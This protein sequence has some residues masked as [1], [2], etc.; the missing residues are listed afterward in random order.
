MP[1]TTDREHFLPFGERQNQAHGLPMPPFTDDRF[2]PQLRGGGAPSEYKSPTCE[3]WESASNPHENSKEDCNADKS[4]PQIDSRDRDSEHGIFSRQGQ[5]TIHSPLNAEVTS[6][7]D[8]VFGKV[9]CKQPPVQR[10]NRACRR[11][12]RRQ[13]PHKSPEKVTEVLT[14]RGSDHVASLETD[15]GSM[16]GSLEVGYQEPLGDPNP[17]RAFILDQP[18]G[19]AKNIFSMTSA[20]DFRNPFQPP[21]ENLAGPSITRARS[22]SGP[23]Q[24]RSS[25]A[26]HRENL[27]C[28][29]RH[30]PKRSI[31]S[32]VYRR[33]RGTSPLWRPYPAFRNRSTHNPFQGTGNTKRLRAWPDQ[34]AGF[35][36]RTSLLHILG[37]HWLTLLV[38]F[39]LFVAI[40][41]EMLRDE[42]F[43]IGFVMLAC[44]IA[45]VR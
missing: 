38:R 15:H 30:V 6:V 10:H 39:L 4:Q 37:L 9:L 21:A 43:T 17:G 14:P 31:R 29:R 28:R 18:K 33:H 1:P 3:S 34:I 13:Y 40:D 5:R 8:G 12:H 35:F 11:R 16:K 44:L 20:Q 45:E 25:L 32:G 19:S 27:E 7:T 36:R 22:L 26:T 42:A 2:L 23:R 24:P 41:R